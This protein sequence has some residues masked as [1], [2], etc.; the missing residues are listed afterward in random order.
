MKTKKIFI[1][2]ALL[3]ASAMPIFSSAQVMPLTASC[4]PSINSAMI[5][6][7][8]TWNS[9][10]YGGNGVYAYSWNGDENLYGNY[11]SAYKTYGTVG[12]KYA[13]LTVYSGGYSM[14]VNC[15][16]INIYQTQQGTIY[17]T[18]Y[19]YPNQV[20]GYSQNSQLS[21]VYLNNVPYTGIADSYAT[22]F[23]LAIE[24][25]SFIVALYFVKNK[26]SRN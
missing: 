23:I 1:T 16:T 18:Q 6:A 10:V 17:P 13:I 9:V 3:I 20:L 25:F 26:Y 21:S 24:L 8:V 14:N 7:T 22:F 11:S 12:A 19:S 5:G 4:Y 2:A 15:G